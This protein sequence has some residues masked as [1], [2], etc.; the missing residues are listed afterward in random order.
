M[1]INEKI[2]LGFSRVLRS[3]LRQDPDIL[4]VGEIR[5][6]ETA[7]IAVRAA[8]T[9]HMVLSTLH[10]NDARSTP[11]RLLD[12]AVPGYMIA[13]TLLAVLSQRLLRLVCSYCAEPA[14]PTPEE[15]TWFKHHM[16]ETEAGTARFMRGRGCARC[17]GVGYSG[18]RGV[19][20]IIEMNAAL[21]QALQQQD[22]TVFDRLA[23][24]QIGAN[25]LVRNALEMVIAGKTTI[26]EAMTVAA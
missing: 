26:A 8:M 21:A 5:D 24:E 17:N 20:E 4:L 16:G 19:F 15:L 11:L 18:R 2:E 7:D 6:N 12:M 23:L 14:T 9:G 13:A 1:Q 3:F 10:T 22:T 25:T